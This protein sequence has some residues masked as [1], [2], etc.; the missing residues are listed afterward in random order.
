[1]TLRVKGKGNRL[2]TIAFESKNA[3][4]IRSWAAVRG[5][6]NGGEPFFVAKRGDGEMRA[7]TVA[8]LDYVVRKNAA[9]AQLSGVH[10]HCLRHTCASLA[11]ANGVN[12]VAIRDLLGHASAIT[13]SRYLHATG[14]AITSV[15]L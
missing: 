4:P 15:A 6:G 12:L 5:T 7:L 9:A 13:T 1:V 14:S 3:G 11:I 8:Q 10:A 2:R